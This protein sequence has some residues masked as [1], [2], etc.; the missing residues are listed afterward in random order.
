MS[1][2]GGKPDMLIML[3]NSRKVKLTMKAMT[4]S[5]IVL[6]ATASAAFAAD[7]IQI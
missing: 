5:L 4:A 1:A 6:L 3:A 2:F 7:E